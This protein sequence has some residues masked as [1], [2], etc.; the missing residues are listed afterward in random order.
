MKK[1]MIAAMAIALAVLP[2]TPAT[3][4]KH[5]G[6]TDKPI[7]TKTA[8]SDGRITF[9][10]RTQT[11]GDCVSF[12]WTGCYLRI[13]FNGPFLSIRAS[14]TGK[15]YFNV[16]LDSSTDKTPDKVISISGKDT[17]IILANGK[18][19]S[20]KGTLS[21]HDVTI[22]KRTEGGSKT[23]IMEFTTKGAVLQADSLKSRQIEFIGDSYTCGYGTEAKK[24]EHFKLETENV[25]YSYAPIVARYFDADYAIIAH[26]GMG[27]ARNYND[28]GKGYYMP[29][30][31]LHTFDVAGTDKWNADSAAFRPAMTVILLGTNDFS[32]GRQPSQ[33]MFVGNYIRLIKEIKANYGEN[34]PI[35]CTAAKGD[36]NI[37]EYVRSAVEKCGLKNVHYMGYGDAVFSEDEYGADWHPNYKA[38]R[39]I[40]HSIIPYISTLTGWEMDENGVK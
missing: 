2:L 4:Q 34:Y 37:F 19:F 21:P 18:D 40:A 25:N 14:E 15:S 16:W 28:A 9:V 6:R 24:G 27:I 36:V 13:K 1:I 39:K 11:N 30:R 33:N 31:Y 23:T 20:A 12:D 38:H 22:Q 32:T 10:G 17:T 3:A 8:A 26:S 35:L 7:F 5:K 29:D